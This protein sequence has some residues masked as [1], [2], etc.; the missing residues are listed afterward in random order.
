MPRKERERL[1][2]DA[3]AEEFGRRGYARG[4]TAVVAARAGISKPMIYEYFTSKDG[5]YL[6]C[7]DRAGSRLVAAVRSAQ[8]GPSDITRAARTLEAVFRALESRVHE[9]ALVYDTTLP[10]DGPLRDAATVHRRELNRLGAVGVAEVLRF[11]GDDEALDADLATHLWYGNVGAAVAWWD[12][13]PEQT[14]EDMIRRFR[15]I[16]AVL[17]PDAPPSGA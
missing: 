15:R 17:Y 14:A 2:L 1:I 13:H 9:W 10:A 12:H 7:L 4:S 5:L 3:A 16:F 8:E 11:S 6:T